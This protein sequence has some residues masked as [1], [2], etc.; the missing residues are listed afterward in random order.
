MD[1]LSTF[2]TAYNN[3]LSTAFSGNEFLVS[4]VS[5]AILGS[6]MYFIKILP[7]KLYRL[8]LQHMTTYVELDS[9][10]I[11]Y[12]NIM[13]TLETIGHVDN[14]RTFVLLNG[15]W[16][17]GIL[18][19]TIGVGTQYMFI[20]NTLVRI[21]VNVEKLDQ[22]LLYHISF[23]T[24]GRSTKF[25][26]KLFKYGK[27]TLNDS[28][29]IKMFISSEKGFEESM[30]VRESL[31]SIVIPDAIDDNII[32]INRFLDSEEWYK[33]HGIPHTLGIILHGKPGVGKTKFIRVLANIIN[34]KTYIINNF[35]TLAKIPKDEQVLVIIE[36]VD[37]LIGDRDALNDNENSLDGALMN[38][39]KSSTIGKA[40]TELDGV[41]QPLSRVVIMTTNYPE[42]IDKALMRPGRLDMVIELTYVAIEDFNKFLKLYYNTT[43][44]IDSYVMTKDTT[45]AELQLSFRQGLTAME[46]ISK[47]LTHKGKI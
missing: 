10:Q 32:E 14:S 2:L 30:Q 45:G 46:F 4:V 31:N 20:F 28:E 29:K 43:T 17:W 34:Y 21:N 22:T 1:K 26:D 7:N 13:T 15:S 11:A 9:K 23:R 41:V 27:E 40:L 37:T 39:I 19:K 44:D 47:H 3:Y 18:R 6:L 25:L 16:G 8:F 12:H 38:S 24:L 35:S 42:K 33:E 36:E 5:T